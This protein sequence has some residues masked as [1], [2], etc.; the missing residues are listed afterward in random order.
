MSHVD[1]YFVISLH[2][3][4]VLFIVGCRLLIKVRYSM[5]TIARIL[6]IR[7]I[8]T[9]FREHLVYMGWGGWGQ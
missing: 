6:L 1:K 3:V 8:Q 5:S 7:K 4:P 9:I 2:E